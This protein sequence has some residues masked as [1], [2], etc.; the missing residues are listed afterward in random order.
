MAGYKKNISEAMRLKE[1]DREIAEK[2]AAIK[3]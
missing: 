2:K 1:K 3:K